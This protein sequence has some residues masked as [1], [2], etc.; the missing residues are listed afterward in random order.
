MAL[1]ALLRGANMFDIVNA[2]LRGSLHA[3]EG[4]VGEQSATWRTRMRKHSRSIQ[5][6]RM[7]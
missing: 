1:C 7:G 5:E 3:S 6:P 4:G 2:T